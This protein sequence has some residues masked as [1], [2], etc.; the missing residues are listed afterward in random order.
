MV[1]TVVECLDITYRAEWLCQEDIEEAHVVNV[2]VSGTIVAEDDKVLKVS[3]LHT[4][5]IERSG[6]LVIIP[7]PC[8]ISRKDQ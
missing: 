1:H 2:V 8:I 3:C 4:P 7:K 6:Y 5:E